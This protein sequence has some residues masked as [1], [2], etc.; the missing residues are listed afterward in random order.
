MESRE[1]IWMNNSEVFNFF[2][3]FGCGGGMIPSYRIKHFQDAMEATGLNY[4]CNFSNKY[5][6][7]N[8][9]LSEYR[10]YYIFEIC[11][12]IKWFTFIL[13]SGISYESRPTITQ[14]WE[15]TSL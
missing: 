1:L 11:D 15:L 14:G 4:V 6:K 2:G 13:K 3:Y 8:Q 9:W 10:S 7:H 5:E 12:R